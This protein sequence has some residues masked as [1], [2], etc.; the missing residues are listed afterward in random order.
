M[1]AKMLDYHLLPRQEIA[2]NLSIHIDRDDHC[3]CVMK[4]VQDVTLISTPCWSAT[5]LYQDKVCCLVWP[6][7]LHTTVMFSAGSVGDSEMSTLMERLQVTDVRHAEIQRINT[8][9]TIRTVVVITKILKP[10]LCFES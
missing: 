4:Y 3:V 8:L 7:S 2:G 5:D 10:I 6:V 1:Y 9:H